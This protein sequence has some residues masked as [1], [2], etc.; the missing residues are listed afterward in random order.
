MNTSGTH[1]VLKKSSSM[2][3][4]DEQVFEDR[5]IPSRRLIH[6]FDLCEIKSNTDEQNE[7]DPQ[8][9]SVADIYSEEV[10]ASSQTKGSAFQNNEN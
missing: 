3:S 8:A 1:V 7:M 9:M 4:E 2:R 6:E 10:L 5:F